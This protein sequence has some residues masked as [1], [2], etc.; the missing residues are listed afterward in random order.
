MPSKVREYIPVHMIISPEPSSISKEMKALIE[1]AKTAYLQNHISR[2]TYLKL[3]NFIIPICLENTIE[4]KINEII[5]RWNKRFN[6]YLCHN[7][8]E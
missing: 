4:N 8:E 6:N 3:M 1:Y 2:D 5:P 7:M